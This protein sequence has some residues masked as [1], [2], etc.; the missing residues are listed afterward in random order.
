MFLTSKT[1]ELHYPSIMRQ[2]SKLELIWKQ[3]TSKLSIEHSV[4]PND[5][6]ISIIYS[7]GVP[8]AFL[9][10]GVASRIFGIPPPAR[11]PINTPVAMI[12]LS[13]CNYLASIQL[14]I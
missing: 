4:R 11:F 14:P 6:S 3:A 8:A 9:L 2:L 7:C 13:F 10:G 1:F 5:F 12:M